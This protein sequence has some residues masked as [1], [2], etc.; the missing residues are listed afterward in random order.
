M[1]DLVAAAP[2][3]AGE[4]N[5]D[6]K[7]A[8]ALSKSKAMLRMGLLNG[9]ITSN[10]GPKQIY[11]MDLEHSKWGYTN[12]CNNLRN[13]RAAIERDRGRMARDCIA[14][15]HDFAIVKEYQA[16][17]PRRQAKPK[18]RGSEAERL[19]KIDVDNGKHL[20]M[21]PFFLHQ[22][23]EAYQMFDLA[24]FGK[25]IYQEID[26][27][28]KQAIRF[29]KKKRGWKYPELHGNNDELRNTLAK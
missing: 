1:T 18:W 15:G 24:V 20:E 21:K 7:E 19:L 6:E 12:W 22:T 11:E 5:D 13:L 29:E 26:R 16:T 4:D 28:P 10:M 8:W 3:D 9:S 25:H 2:S 23:N 14:Y 17:N 27:R